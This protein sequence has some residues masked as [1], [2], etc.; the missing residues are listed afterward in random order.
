[1]FKPSAFPTHSS[2]SIH[3]DIPVVPQCALQVPS[4]LS[5]SSNDCKILIARVSMFGVSDAAKLWLASP[6]HAQA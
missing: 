2:L 4:M 6:G 1:M 3:S 5:D